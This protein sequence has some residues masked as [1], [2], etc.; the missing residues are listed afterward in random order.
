MTIAKH[1]YF[2]NARAVAGV[3]VL[4]TIVA[5]SWATPAAAAQPLVVAPSVAVQYS[6]AD[7]STEG[8]AKKLYER[9]ALA[10]RQVCPQY[11]ARDLTAFSASRSCQRQAIAGAVAQVGNRRLAALSGLPA[12]VG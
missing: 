10:A 7:L 5:S 12:H 1:A 9:I 3:A 8:G 4:A 11:D 2:L 6:V